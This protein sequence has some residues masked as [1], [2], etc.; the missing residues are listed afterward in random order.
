M[1]NIWRGSPG[2]AYLLDVALKARVSP[3][4]TGE[5]MC[6]YGS[7]ARDDRESNQE[8]YKTLA[9]GRIVKQYYNGAV[10][11]EE[12]RWNIRVGWCQAVA[13]IWRFI[14]CGET[15]EKNVLACLCSRRLQRLVNHPKDN[16]HVAKLPLNNP[17]WVLIMNQYES[18]SEMLGC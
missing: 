6:L 10:G 12:T 14:I 9:S 16:F 15:A 1:D 17:L 18:R 13:E 7:V 11:N 3:Q 2:H 5:A 4:N 8:Q